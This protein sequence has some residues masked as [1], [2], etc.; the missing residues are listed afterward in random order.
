MQT[1]KNL[2][3]T[4]NSSSEVLYFKISGNSFQRFE[5]SVCDYFILMFFESG[6]GNH[7]IDKVPY[8]ILPFQMHVYFPE[9]THYYQ[10]SS[11]A[12]VHEI[13]ISNDF[14]RFMSQ[15]L[16]H[17]FAYYKK[18]P[19]ITF[20]PEVFSRIIKECIGIRDELNMDPGIQQIIK[21]RLH[22]IS[23]MISREIYD[24]LPD[25]DNQPPLLLE[26]FFELVSLHHKENR[27]VSF[28]AEKLGITANYLTVLCRKYYASTATSIIS[29]ETIQSIKTY[30]VNTQIS[31]KE[32]ALE[33]NFYEMSTFSSFF[34]KHTGKSPTAYREL[35][36]SHTLNSQ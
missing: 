3:K 32:I 9:Q 1:F 19:V 30:L 4:F 14:F 2:Q 21:Y 8:T 28:Y 16:D 7:I 27:L 26:K 10:L 24:H 12:I 29:N 25:A 33:H 18:N 34:K 20:A 17:S 15:H 35:H 31:I 6:S 13:H 5:P 36:S 11:D 23:M 22:I